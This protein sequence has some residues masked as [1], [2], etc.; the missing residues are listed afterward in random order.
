MCVATK[1]TIDETEAAKILS[2]T[3]TKYFLKDLLTKAKQTDKKYERSI[4]YME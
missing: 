4:P 2:Y 1:P 3:A